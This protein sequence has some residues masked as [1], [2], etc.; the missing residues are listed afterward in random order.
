MISH[1]LFLQVC[2]A[3]YELMQTRHGDASE[4]FKSLDDIYYFGGQRSHHLR[5]LENHRVV[6]LNEMSDMQRLNESNIDM[7]RL[8]ELRRE[9]ERRGKRGLNRQNYKTNQNVGS[10]DQQRFSQLEFAQQLFKQKTFGMTDLYASKDDEVEI[11]GNL[12]N[13]FSIGKNVISKQIGYFPSYKAV[14]II[15]RVKMPT[16]PEVP[17]T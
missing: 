14:D 13:G 15:Q 6:A 2:R 7:K 3:A 9:L 11:H 16:Y 10:V 12:W 5:M 4:R 1:N 8:K 17:E